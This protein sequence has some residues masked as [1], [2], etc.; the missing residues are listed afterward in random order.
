MHSKQGFM[1]DEDLKKQLSHLSDEELLA[2]FVKGDDRMMQAL[3]QRHTNSIFDF[4]RIYSVNG[5]MAD[6]VFK[7]TFIRSIEQ[8]R[9][10]V[11]P[12]NIVF[13]DW[14]MNITREEMANALINMEKKILVKLHQPVEQKFS[15]NIQSDDLESLSLDVK[16]LLIKHKKP[17]KK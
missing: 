2:L 5:K 8:I 16:N 15:K 6:E 10:R 12:E 9:S 14:L 3:I 4:I 13:A 1:L 11:F 7:S 17:S